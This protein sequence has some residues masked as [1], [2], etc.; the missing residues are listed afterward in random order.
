[1]ASRAAVPQP[2]PNGCAL[3]SKDNDFRQLSFLYGAPP[4]I[5]WLSGNAGTDAIAAPLEHSCARVEALRHFTV[6]S[7]GSG[8]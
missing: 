6:G 3:V 2:E 4:K 1:L 5:I 8:Y 7:R